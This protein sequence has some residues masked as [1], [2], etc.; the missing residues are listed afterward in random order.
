MS[1]KIIGAMTKR[2][3]TISN[4]ESRILIVVEHE[5]FVH[6]WIAKDSQAGRDFP[7]FRDTG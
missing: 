2:L 1:T 7:Q 3:K 6:L 4:L 5:N